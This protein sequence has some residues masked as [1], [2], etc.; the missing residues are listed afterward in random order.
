VPL[1]R[2][3]LK[4]TRFKTDAE[5]GEIRSSIRFSAPQEIICL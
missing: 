2:L 3:V 4:L 1:A 5:A